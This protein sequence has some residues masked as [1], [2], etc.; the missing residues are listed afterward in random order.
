MAKSITE[1]GPKAL[2]GIRNPDLYPAKNDP[3]GSFFTAE[4][5]EQIQRDLYQSTLRNY[6]VSHGHIGYEYLDQANFTPVY[7]PDLDLGTSMFDDPVMLNATQ[8]DIQD[9]RAENQPWYAKIGAGIGKA[10]VYAGTTF[11][12]GTAG[13]LYGLGKWA[14]GGNF[15]DVWNNEVTVA[16][17]D[18]MKD[19]EQLMPNYRTQYE[20]EHP[21]A[22]ENIFS[23]NFLGDSIIKNIGFLVGAYY[24]GGIFSKGAG[25]LLR[26]VG[27]SR[28][29]TYSTKYLG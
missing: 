5:R 26:A 4:E 24:S 14:T 8:G 28:V 6:Q 23:A 21:M 1:T 25:L 22:L 13:L 12:N 20:Q 10:V 16:M 17:D 11:A 2:R 3:L 7:R 15:S 27:A 29:V 9:M 18:I 19:S